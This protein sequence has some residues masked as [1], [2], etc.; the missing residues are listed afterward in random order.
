MPDP[1]GFRDPRLTEQRNPA[2]EEIDLATPLDIVELLNREDRRVP[3]A[4]WAVRHDVAKA[5]DLVE[6]AFHAGGR[7]LYVGAGTSGRLGVLDASECPPTFGTDP[8]MVVGVIA[9]GA[10]AL[11]RS[12]ESAEDDFDAGGDAIDERRPTPHD[13][14]FGIAASGTTPFVRGAIARAAARGAT[15][16]LLSCTD[17]PQDVLANTDVAILPKVGPEALTGSTRLKAGTATKLVLNA[18][19]TGAMIR[20]GRAYGNLM[21]D[22]VA[23]AEKLRD[24]GERIVMEVSG[25]DRETARA[26]IAA[27]DGR[28]KLAI[29]MQRLGVPLAEAE[30]KLEEAGGFVRRAVGAPPT[31]PHP[32]EPPDPGRRAGAKGDG[33]AGT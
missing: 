18:V 32:D 30:R 2:T 10:A 23:T 21:V 11:V 5:I 20:T 13:V 8:S 4:V 16:I 3:E 6:H 31:S 24:R 14:V 9:G 25:A 26:A 1:A 22:L 12:M 27:A 33:A 17:P 19:T 29:V 28:V 7:L 15:T